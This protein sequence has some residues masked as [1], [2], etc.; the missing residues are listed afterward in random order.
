MKRLTKKEIEHIREYLPGYIA[1]ENT[2][3]LSDEE[4]QAIYNLNEKKAGLFNGEVSSGSIANKTH[5]KLVVIHIKLEKYYHIAQL[6]KEL[7]Q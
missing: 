4:L 1:G 2:Q 5:H 3:Y 6:K 7:A